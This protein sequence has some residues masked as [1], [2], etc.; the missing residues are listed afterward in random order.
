MGDVGMTENELSRIIIGAAI[1]VHK[2]LGGPE[3]LEDMY[4]EAL[5]V[6]LQSQGLRVERQVNVAVIYKG[7]VLGKLYRLDLL[8]EGFVVVECKAVEADHS[9]HCAQCLT[10][11]RLTKKRLGL[12]I[13]FGHSVL[14][15]GIHRVVNGLEE[16]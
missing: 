3:L 4:E 8:V 9:I 13:N 10:H 7:H 5:C 2:E 16:G 15:N 11:L 6:E 12:V 14:K 1:E